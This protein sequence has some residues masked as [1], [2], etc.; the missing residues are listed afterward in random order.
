M[1]YG[2]YGRNKFV[3]TSATEI[4]VMSD[5]NKPDTLE[6]FELGVDRIDVA[7]WGAT[8]IDDLEITTLQSRKGNWVQIGDADGDAE[9][10]VRF[11]GGILP[12][13]SL[14]TADSFVFAG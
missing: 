11:E 9:L 14:L 7:A 10:M 6:E 5:D 12:D 8:S 1:I 2:N 4:F 3:G 13:A